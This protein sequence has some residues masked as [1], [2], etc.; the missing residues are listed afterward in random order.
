MLGYEKYYPAYLLSLKGSKRLKAFINSSKNS[1]LSIK[2]L[3]AYYLYFT[4]Y[5]LRLKRLKS[6]HSYIKKQVLDEYNSS[7]LENLTKNYKN[8]TDLQKLE[9]RSTQ[10]PHLLKYED[11]NSM[12][13]SVEA[14]LPFLDYNCVETALAVS[15]E[16][17][18]KDGW[19]KYLLRKA[20]DKKLPKEITWRKNKL[21]FNAP[22]NDWL[23]KLKPEMIQEIKTSKIL[24]EITNLEIISFDSRGNYAIMAPF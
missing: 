23:A 15:N 2:D 9:L 14:R 17:K 12:L 3:L 16:F 10:L 13:H 4:R 22:E 20:V 1:K 5:N 7:V 6:K 19:T 24:K 8:I 18:I 11:K 21:G